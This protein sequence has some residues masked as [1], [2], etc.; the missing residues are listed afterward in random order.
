MIS[1]VGFLGT[2]FCRVN[3]V[4]GR[5]KPLMSF[6]NE[7]YSRHLGRGVAKIAGRDEGS[8]MIARL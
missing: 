1:Q 3:M 4:P 8:S 2:D 6:S 5:D 7:R